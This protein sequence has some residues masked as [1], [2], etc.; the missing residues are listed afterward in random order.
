MAKV[1]NSSFPERKKAAMFA[2]VDIWQARAARLLVILL[3]CVQPL[4]LAPERYFHLTYHKWTFLVFSVFLV[5]IIVLIIWTYR[6]TRRPMLMPQDKLRY[7]DWA[8][9]AFALI[10]I[11]STIFSPFRD[12]M[13]IWIGLEQPNERY[14]GAITQLMYVAVF[15]IVSRWYRPSKADFGIFGI[16]ASLV[17]LIGVFQFYGMDFFNLWPNHIP[18]HF[19]ENFFDIFFRTTLGNVNIVSTY[20]TIAILLC[21]FLF[22][23]LRSKWQP[24]WL[25]ASAFCFW[26]MDIA[27]SDSGLVG[28]AVVMFLAIPFI[29]ETKKYLGRTL[30][31]ISSW[32]AVFTIQRLFFDVM[33]LEVRTLTSLLPLFAVVAVLVG[34]GAVLLRFS[35][36]REEGSPGKWKPGVLII[37]VVV[38]ASLIGIEFFGRNEATRDDGFAQRLLFEAREVLHGNLSDDMGS[39]RVLIWR[40]A[41]TDSFLQNPIIG[42]GPDTFVHSFPQWANELADVR[43][44]TAHNEYIQIL[45]THGILGLLAYLVFLAGVFV[46]GIK[47]AFY[48][49]IKMAVLAAFA[50][51]LV[52][53][54]FNINLPIVSQILWVFAGILAISR[55][56]DE[57]WV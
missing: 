43:F 46:K 24:L 35:K 18:E 7:F 56:E 40:G 6:L 45:I 17:A 21:G 16:S 22:I 3:I 20:V 30:I 36:E 5:L 38:V 32:A 33:T 44:D 41:L 57:P 28:V 8:V 34:A 48:D 47:R 11:V 53:A 27:G 9:L 37:I 50:G 26:L 25:A 19:R 29:I 14:D 12:Q 4:Y 39:Y 55:K 13:N 51:Y 1:S 54:F 15:F 49:P 23:R 52:Q 42:T 2:K 10:T 31:L